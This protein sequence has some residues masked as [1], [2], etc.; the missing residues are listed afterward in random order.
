MVYYYVDTLQRYIQRD[1]GIYNANNKQILCDPKDNGFMGTSFPQPHCH[2]DGSLGFSS[3]RTYSLDNPLEDQKGICLPDR[4]EDADCILHEYAHSILRN[5]KNDYTD[6]GPWE[7]PNSGTNRLETAAIKEGFADILATVYFA[8]EHNAFQ[9]DVFEDWAYA[10]RAETQQYPQYGGQGGLR[11]MA[12]ARRYP[13]GWGADDHENGLFWSNTMWDIYLAMGGASNDLNV[14]IAARN[15]L[16]K[17]HLLS[18][19][20]IINDASL[21][22][23]AEVFTQQ[24]LALPDYQGRHAKAILQKFHD[25]AILECVPGSKLQIVELR[26]QGYPL[27]PQ[28]LVAHQSQLQAQMDRA[29]RLALISSLRRQ[30]TSAEQTIRYGADNWFFV[31]ITNEGTGAARSGVVT[32]SF[33]PSVRRPRIPNA[34]SPS[35]LY[36]DTLRMARS[37]QVCGS[38]MFDLPSFGCR[39][40]RARFPRDMIPGAPYGVIVAEVWNPVDKLPSR[41]TR[42]TGEGKLHACIAIVS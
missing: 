28:E 42:S 35:T 17:T 13:Q 25:H 19:F 32:F 9:P 20:Q 22:D 16:L 14:R 15:E 18:N 29:G 12:G 21:P 26:S 38:V 23:A 1:L 6:M 39:V 40:L 41:F 7:A 24:Y 36:S 8:P 10:H 5:Q 4:A 30:N 31:L 27:P 34:L 2:P 37:Q 33:L 11:R 3:P